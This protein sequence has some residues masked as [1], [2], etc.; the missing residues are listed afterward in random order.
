MTDVIVMKCTWEYAGEMVWYVTKD[1]VCYRHNRKNVR[2]KDEVKEFFK[3][4]SYELLKDGVSKFYFNPNAF[5][6]I[7]S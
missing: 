3:M 6:R 2:T 5:R 1:G 7:K 4:K